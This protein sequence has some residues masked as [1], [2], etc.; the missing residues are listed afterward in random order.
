MKVLATLLRPYRRLVIG[1]FVVACLTLLPG[2]ATSL[3]MGYVV[4]AV[5][6]R[7]QAAIRQWTLT[8]IALAIVGA[9][10]M[11]P[12]ARLVLRAAVDAEAGI[13]SRV[14]DR[15]LH[16]DVNVVRAMPVGQVVSRATADLRLIRTFLSGSI[17]SVAQVVTGYAFLLAVTGM[18]HPFLALAALIPV[19]SVVVL[20]ILRVRAD[21]RSAS[22][23]RDALGDATT[24]LDD[25]LRGIEVLRASDATGAAYERAS[26]MIRD[27]RE[28]LTGVIR[29][30]ATF[31]AVLTAIPYLAYALVLAIGVHLVLTSP[32]FDVGELVTVSLLM[33]HVASP[34]TALSGVIAQG[35]GAVAAAR[36][37]TEVIDWPDAPG[38]PRVPGAQLAITNLAAGPLVDVTWT[39]P[40]GR[41]LGVEGSSNSGKSTLLQVL[42]GVRRDTS[43]S[44]VIPGVTA[45]SSS[46]DLV[47]VGTIRDAVTYGN[48]SAS[49][50]EVEDAACRARL[51]EVV[52]ELADGWSTRLGGRG[53]TVLSGGQLQRVRLARGLL[54]DADL[55]LLDAPTVGLDAVTKAHVEQ[56]ILD[57]RSGRALVVAA[58][59]PADLGLVDARARIVDGSLDVVT[60]Q[61]P[62][63]A[64]P[65]QPPAPQTLPMRAAEP[66]KSTA[67]ANSAPT[68]S[69][70]RSGKDA[71]RERRQKSRR[72]LGVVKSVVLPDW[73]FLLLAVLAVLVTTV[74][75]LVPIYLSMLVVQDVITSSGAERLGPV[76]ILMAVVAVLSGVS[77]FAAEFLIPWIGQRGL[78][79]L[80]LRA[81]QSLLRTHLA[82]YDS[83]QVGAIVSRLTNNIELLSD[84]I[85]S[86]ARSIISAVVM[87]VT[88]G[89][90][91]VILD[92]ELALVAYVIVPAILALVWAVRR[93][94]RWALSKNTAGISDVT[95]AVRDAVVGA[96]TIRSFHAQ[97]AHRRHFEEVNELERTALLRSGYVF[98]AFAGVMQL[99]VALDVALVVAVGGE[100]AIA[101]AIATTTMVLF[102]TYIQNGVTPVST[103][104]SMQATYGQ[105]GVAMDQIVRMIDLRP[106]PQLAGSITPHE[107]EARDCP[108][109]LE[110]ADVWFAYSNAGGWIL[111]GASLEVPVGATVALVGPTGSGKSSF[112][113]LALRFYSPIK[114]EV[115]LFGQPISSVTEEWL[116]REVAYVPQEPVVF[117]G[118]IRSNL[119][120]ARPEASDADIAAVLETLG[121]SFD[122]DSDMGDVSTGERQLVSI[123]RAIIARRP[124]VILDEATSHLDDEQIG[125]VLAALRILEPATTV[126]TI[127]HQLELASQADLVAVVSHRTISEVGTHA[128][129]LELKGTYARLWNAHK[130]AV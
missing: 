8:L 22:T 73:P 54:M 100:R 10:L 74:C 30:N 4:E 87:L 60:D 2:L 127:V 46:D 43:G 106:D 105:A 71:S 113:K 31:G 125:R 128:E 130:V 50:A 81:F 37:V 86:G 110:F 55:L 57:E 17:G 126:L 69:P 25:S 3:I 94:Q 89:M 29:R 117:D 85:T 91:L 129:L 58:T 109:A 45:M 76:I 11:A 75:T 72:R 36:R 15:I 40:S 53:G 102:A 70:Q 41:S 111:K 95:V 77:L 116:R 66:V 67:H 44:V 123:A 88:V 119:V 38:D 64:L 14:F 84:V 7:D 47:F 32:G 13:R 52:A 39:L 124:L 48:P 99:L 21:T 122:L 16:A 80:R 62:V 92:R 108:A 97:D 34:T 83:Q 112:V 28:A 12:R 24:I 104:A 26:R 79:R 42:Q 1:A 51:D 63:R 68:S 103:I 107:P 120:L 65:V 33:L 114:G 6:S 5:T 121:L 35:Q 98:K 82:Y 61:V 101:G 23:S 18:H 9:L 115:R 56:G 118:T 59:R 49:D 20:T 19:G 93:G 96:T 78:G 27:A 90:L